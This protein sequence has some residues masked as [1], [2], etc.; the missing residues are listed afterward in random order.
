MKY[1]HILFLL[2]FTL[3]F[4][5][6]E[7]GKQE[8]FW[9]QDFDKAKQL[10]KKNDKSILMY[11]TG[12]DWC[13]PCMMLKEDFFSSKK[14]K[15][16]KDSY[17]FLIVDIPRNKDLLTETQKT[18]NYK[19][20]KEYNINK[21]FPLVSILSAKGK[22]LDQVSGYSPLRDPKYHFELLEKFK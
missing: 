8:D 12:S 6:N 1:L 5:Q 21:V 13:S 4:S 18:K 3:G 10:A 15:K 17:V 11:F 9:L 20:L 19:L 14:F 2:T 22:T 16:Y 7:N